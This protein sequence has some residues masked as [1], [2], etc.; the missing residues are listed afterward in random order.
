MQLDQFNQAPEAEIHQFLQQCVHIPAWATVIAQQ[1]PFESIEQL[2]EFS[3]QLASHWSWPEIQAALANHPRISEKQAQQELTAQEQV[4]S[5]REQAAVQLNSDTQQALLQ[6][7]LAYEKKFGFIFLIKAF[8]L[9]SEDILQ[10]LQYRLLN[11]A[12]T[13]Q[14]IV[15][16][17]L[18]DIALLRLSQELQP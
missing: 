4:F 15:Q 1:R 13:E 8:G 12:D 17:Q 14:R 16:Q 7:N 11:D 3:R 18:S 10:A 6:G 2:L 5:A 9:S